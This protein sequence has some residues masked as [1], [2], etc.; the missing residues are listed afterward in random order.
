MRRVVRFRI[1]V[2]GLFLLLGAGV[3]MSPSRPAARLQ[4][5]TIARNAGPA[6]DTSHGARREAAK[7][8]QRLCARCHGEDFTGAALRETVP[9]APDFTRRTWQSSRTDGTLLATILD[10]KGSEM[11][12]FRDK[13]TAEQADGLVALIRRAGPTGAAPAKAGPD[14]FDRR[15]GELR[16]QLD[17]LQ[18]QYRQLSPAP[19]KP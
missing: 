17:E 13:L 19:G 6:P 8:F 18:R 5:G 14:D 4:P 3:G 16:K 9:G 11:P 12:P 2:F 7:D 1:A 10:G 15:Y